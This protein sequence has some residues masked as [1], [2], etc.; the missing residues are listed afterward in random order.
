MSG[1]I[2]DISGPRALGR[3][4]LAL[5]WIGGICLLSVVL[6]VAAG[7]FMRYVM[8]TPIL[9][10]NEIVQLAALALVMSAMPYC[11]FGN[12]HVNVDVFDRMLGA[13]G[14]LLG[15]VLARV[16]SVFVLGVLTHRAVLKAL[17]A[18]EWGDATNMLGLP[19]WP[20]YGILAAGAGLCVIVYAVQIVTLLMRGARP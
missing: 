9:G 11:T 1:D 18:L 8:H 6:I 15:D 20:F 4:T 3:A 14:R 17:D 12:H 10:V 13:Y 16:L 2:D 7:V 5:T 19:I